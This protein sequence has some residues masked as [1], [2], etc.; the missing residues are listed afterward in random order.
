MKFVK[1]LAL[2]AFL[3]LSGCYKATVTFE[4]GSPGAEQRVKVHALIAGLVS[5]NDIDANKVC[6]DKGVW[7]VSSR[8]NVIDMLLGML[9]SGIYT[10]VTVLVT[11]KG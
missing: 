1:F 10:P 8:H 9:T 3:G 5:L 2:A 4:G 7:S 6:G 11:C